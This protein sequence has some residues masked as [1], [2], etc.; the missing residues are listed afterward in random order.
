MGTKYNMRTFF[1]LN[2]ITLRGAKCGQ[3]RLSKWINS[4]PS[5][6]LLAVPPLHSSVEVQVL[7]IP[8]NHQEMM[9]CLNFKS[10]AQWLQ[11]IAEKKDEVDGLVHLQFFYESIDTRATAESHIVISSLYGVLQI[12]DYCLSRSLLLQV[13]D[14]LL[15]LGG[16]L[17][18]FYD[19]SS[20]IFTSVFSNSEN[21]SLSSSH[22]LRCAKTE[23]YCVSDVPS[24]GYTQTEVYYVSDVP[25]QRIALRDL[26]SQRCALSEYFNRFLKPV[27]ANDIFE[28]FQHPVIMLSLTFRLHHGN[29]LNLTLSNIIHPTYDLKFSLTIFEIIRRGPLISYEATPSG[30]AGTSISP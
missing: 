7:I 18:Q 30:A 22:F 27:A 8:V 28:K 21:L 17:L 24:Q 10:V 1:L 20:R 23:E 4:N 9:Y 2:K 29:L 25:S 14:R 13:V 5:V 19:L 11:G 15:S 6:G 26:S 3:Q 16:D 12:H